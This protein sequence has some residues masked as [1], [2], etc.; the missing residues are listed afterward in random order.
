MTKAFSG[1]KN[2]QGRDK[3]GDWTKAALQ[4]HMSKAGGTK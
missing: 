2:Q 4:G 1:L 3:E